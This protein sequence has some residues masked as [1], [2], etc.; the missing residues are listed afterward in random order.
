MIYFECSD[1]GVVASIRGEDIETALPDASVIGR[2]DVPPN[3]RFTVKGDTVHVVM[4]GNHEFGFTLNKTQYERLA[5]GSVMIELL[6][7]VA[8]GYVKIIP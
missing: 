3:Y 6:P 7:E 5:S 2:E 8:V 4:N 1:N